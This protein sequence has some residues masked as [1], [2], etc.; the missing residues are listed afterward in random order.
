[1]SNQVLLEKLDQTAELLS[2]KLSQLIKLSALQSSDEND[3]DTSN[4]DTSTYGLG[5]NSNRTIPE[6]EFNES[7]ISIATSGI[8]MVHNQ[9]MQ[10]IKG[11]QDLLVLTRSIRERWLL[12]QIP[13]Q[14]VS[15]RNTEIDHEELKQLLDQCIQEIIGTTDR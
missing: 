13:D 9:T 10:L 12:N 6:M 3:D 1:M 15:T 4:R 2:V 7:D 14:G 5:N 11:I 8:T